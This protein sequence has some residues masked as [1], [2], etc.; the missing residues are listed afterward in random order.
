MHFNWQ[1]MYSR[2]SLPVKAILIMMAEHIPAR[3]RRPLDISGMINE[4]RT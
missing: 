3:R 4:C 2:R 1:T